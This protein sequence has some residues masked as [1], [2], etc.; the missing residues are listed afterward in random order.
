MSLFFRNLT[1]KS[2][3]LEERSF[4]LP[5]PADG[6]VI[7]ELEGMLKTPRLPPAIEKLVSSYIERSCGKDWHTG[8]TARLLWAYID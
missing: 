3:N 6:Q 7:H 4:N 2:D 5:L 1:L 8:E